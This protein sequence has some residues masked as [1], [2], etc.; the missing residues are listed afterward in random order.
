MTVLVPAYDA[1]V[2][3]ALEAAAESASLRVVLVGTGDKAVLALATSLRAKGV[4]VARI[5]P[6]AVAYALRELMPSQERTVVLCGAAAL[7]STGGFI[8]P[9]GTRQAAEL[10][11]GGRIGVICLAELFK[12]A[13][14]LPHGG[15]LDEMLGQKVLVYDGEWDEGKESVDITVSEVSL[16]KCC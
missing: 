9:M 12:I 13:T 6:E 7:L 1:L 10:A 4:P 15:K 11:K 5:R 2:A 14:A 8:A 16:M 3:A